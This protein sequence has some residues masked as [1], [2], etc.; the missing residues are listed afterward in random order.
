MVV[1]IGEDT[2][3]TVGSYIACR[4]KGQS[5]MLGQVTAV[6]ADDVWGWMRQKGDKFAQYSLNHIQVQHIEDGSV[7]VKLIN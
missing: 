6:T 4:R 5:V 1:Q 2:L 3:V 7:K